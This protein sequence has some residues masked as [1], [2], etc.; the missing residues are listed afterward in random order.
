MTSK[1]CILLLY[2]LRNK[3]SLQSEP[4]LTLR[5]Y[6]YASKKEVCLLQFLSP[7]QMDSNVIA[8]QA[9]GTVA[10]QWIL[11]SLTKASEGTLKLSWQILQ[12]LCNSAKLNLQTIHL[13]ISCVC[14]FL[15]NKG[16]EWRI[17]HFPETLKLTKRGKIR[18]HKLRH[19][20]LVACNPTKL[21]GILVKACY[22]KHTF[23]LK[24]HWKMLIGKIFSALTFAIILVTHKRTNQNKFV[25]TLA[26]S[27]FWGKQGEWYLVAWMTVEF[28]PF[29]ASGIRSGHTIL[30]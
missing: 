4:S 20:S 15:R 24:N 16:R 8:P 13:G 5:N 29:A 11:R 3:V 26:F 30:M 9:L 12:K 28:C 2:L 21:I 6:E 17:I 7:G 14:V 25:L 1:F 22:L 19:L 23:Y 10:L 27:G 18:E